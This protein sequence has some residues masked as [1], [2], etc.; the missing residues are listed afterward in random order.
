[1]GQGAVTGQTC[2]YRVKD[3][4][5]LRSIAADY[6]IDPWTLAR[7]NRIYDLNHIFTGQLIV[8]PDCN[9]LPSQ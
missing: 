4:D 7:A 8:I 2:E 1:L 5:T 9:R 3:G 6:G